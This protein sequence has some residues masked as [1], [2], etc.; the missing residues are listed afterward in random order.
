GKTHKDVDYSKNISKE[1][2]ESA[3]NTY[4]ENKHDSLT[5]RNIP[6]EIK[7]FLNY[8]YRF[9]IDEDANRKK[10][11]EVKFENGDINPEH[12]VK[13]DIEHIVPF[14]KFANFGGQIPMSVLGN[15]CYLAVK[16]NRSKRNNTIYEYSKDRP[17]LTYDDDFIKMIDYPTYEELKFIDCPI[18]Q[19]KSPFESLVSRREKKMI[20]KFIAF[21][22][23]SN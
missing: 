16:D 21:I 19:F 15:L 3:I 9:L 10:Y 11:F 2:W 6:N 17:A 18:D 1:Y 12:E 20:N 7:L 14:E 4:L 8:Y 13:F 5:S 22:T 23:D